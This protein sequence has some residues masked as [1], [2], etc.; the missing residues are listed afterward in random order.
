MLKIKN[1]G[2]SS[3]YPQRDQK[4]VHQKSTLSQDKNIIQYEPKSVNI[5]SMPYFNVL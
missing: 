4:K 3:K 2:Q 1:E 5:L